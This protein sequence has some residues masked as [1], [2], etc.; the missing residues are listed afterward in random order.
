[1]N[2][3]K[4]EALLSEFLERLRSSSTGSAPTGLDPELAQTAQGLH[5]H[6]RLPEADSAAVARVKARALELT[7][8]NLYQA[9]NQR[10]N[11]DGDKILSFL[12]GANSN[13]VWGPRFSI[14]FTLVIAVPL[15]SFT[16]FGYYT[17]L[18]RVLSPTPRPVAQYTVVPDAVRW[19]NLG[20]HWWLGYAGELVSTAFGSFYTQHQDLMVPGRLLDVN[21]TRA[22]NS[23]DTRVGMFGLG[24]HDTYDMS[25]IDR[26]DGSVI[27]TFGDG[28]AGL[29]TPDGG[30]GYTAP[31]GFFAQLANNGSERV[32]TDTDQTAYTFSADGKLIRI[33]GPHG[34]QINLAH[35]ETGYT[36][37]DTVGREFRADFNSDG[38]IERITGPEGHNYTYEYSGNRLKAFHYPL[39]GVMRYTYNSDGL[40][41]SV[42]DANNHTFVTNEYDA[43][44][45]VVRQL[46]ASGNATTFTYSQSPFSTTIVDPENHTTVHEFDSQYR[47]VRETDALGHSIVYAYDIDNNRTYMK[48]RGDH[49]TFMQYDSRGNMTQR[50]DAAGG[51][52]TYQYDARN[53][54]TLERNAANEETAYTY[55]LRDNLTQV[56]DAENGVKL[57]TYTSFGQLQTLRDA[58]LHVTHFSYDGQGNLTEIRDALNNVTGYSYDGV[59]RRTSMTDANNHTT[60]FT[61]DANDRLTQINDPRGNSTLFTYD[62]VGNLLNMRDRRGYVTQYFYDEN[63]SLK[64]VLD[65][66]NSQTLYTY[67]RMY[68]RTSETNPRNFTTQYR[69]DA[70]YN[71]ER[72]IDAKNNVTRFEYDADR[73]MTRQIDALNGTTIFQYDALHRPIRVTD[74]LTGVTEYAYDAVGRRIQMRDARQ[75]ITRY[76]Y[77]HLGRLVE[78]T[79]ALN[80]HTLLGYD[81]VGN[82]TS[83]TNARRVTTTSRYDDANRLIE[84]SDPLGRLVAYSYDGVGNVRT[85]TDANGNVTQYEYDANE[86]LQ[87]AIDALNGVTQ[88]TYDEED[89]VL[90]ERDANNH[91]RTYGYDQ[92]GNVLTFTLPLG[93]QTLYAYD[94]NGNLESITNAKN[95]T[96][97]FGYDQLDLLR[98]QTTPLG[99]VTTNDYDPLRRLSRLTDAESHVTQYRYDAL[100]RL[101]IVI[102]ALNG[103]TQ[104][105]YDALGYMT[106]Y[107]D[108]NNH[109]TRFDVDLLGRTTRETDPLTHSWNYTYDGVGNT[110]TRL[111]ANLKLT[112]YA[113]DQRNRLA[114]TAYPSG[115]NVVYTY[116]PNG[117]L[118]ALADKSGSAQ[119]RYDPLDRLTESLRT[120]GILSGKKLTNRYDAVGNLLRVTYPDGNY[121]GYQYN[122]NDWQVSV[123]DPME[124]VTSYRHDDVGLTTR[125]TNPNGTWTDFRYDNDDRKTRVFNGK[126]EANSNLIS[127]FDYTLDRVGNRTRTIERMTRGQVI[128]WDK[129]YTYDPLYRLT[130]SVLTPGYNPAQS[131]TSEFTYDAV[132]NRR[133]MA[134]NIQDKPN[135]PPLR[136]PVTTQYTY[137]AANQMLTVGTTRFTYDA[138]GNRMAMSG[139]TRAIDYAYDFE[140]RLSSATTYDVLP[141]GSHK[142]DSTLDY[143]YDSLGR[144]IERGVI[145]NGVR[146]I[147]DFLYDGLGYD[148]LAQYVD[149]GEPRTTYY[150]RDLSQILSRHE[151]QGQGAGLQYFYHYDG[152]G[153]VSAWTNQSG[154]GVQEYT[155]SPYGRL[156]DN[157]GP[158]N[159]SNRTDP[160]NSVTWS[161]KMWD[162][163]TEL[164]HFGARDYDP[165]AGVWLTRDLY[166]GELG[167]PTSLHRYQYVLNNPTTLIDPHG[168]D[169]QSSGLNLNTMDW[170][171]MSLPKLDQSIMYGTNSYG[172]GTNGL[173]TTSADSL[174][175]PSTSK[176]WL[177]GTHHSPLTKSI[178]GGSYLG[179]IAIT[180]NFIPVSGSTAYEKRNLQTGKWMD[181]PLDFVFNSLNES[182]L[183]AE[184]PDT[185][186]KRLRADL[187]AGSSVAG[188]YLLVVGKATEIVAKNP[189]TGRI[190]YVGLGISAVYYGYGNLNAGRGLREIIMPTRISVVVPRV[191]ETIGRTAA[192][193]RAVRGDVGLWEHCGVSSYFWAGV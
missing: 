165:S 155:Y 157:T 167:E 126:P 100:G 193:N 97:R 45:R 170:R 13:R 186:T 11:L 156:I 7:R 55:D 151:I 168:F 21:F 174:S 37:T 89:N 54:L 40:L 140:N 60:L 115:T 61:Y 43:Q 133:A 91:T 47:L 58:N 17:F 86:N 106:S 20:P 180:G 102:D 158:D 169:S 109:R 192:V 114:S 72:V 22:Y 67:D 24:W 113:Y 104:Y 70:V 173:Y 90:T 31:D 175:Q 5:L 39:G 62:L 128:T 143:T 78:V 9:Q 2:S 120:A 183:V 187:R 110:L 44:G 145:D 152:S 15:L 162:K 188:G 96:T 166:R 147:A 185:L 1:M 118:T 46:D 85:R 14:L 159:A 12:R 131:L 125:M 64:R 172:A 134:T 124:G 74:A 117:N 107:I 19:A 103:Q 87:R 79:D 130:K 88:F 48:D 160:H 3:S 121:V 182:S 139:S 146:K 4:Q 137:D 108:A 49:E 164:Y 56:H 84:Q 95:N 191:G 138:N 178:S 135:T 148:M 112:R 77:D 99:N 181:D 57:M 69:Y 154:R 30:G 105:E 35:D 176:I 26:G 184:F 41:T 38:F 163:E 10:W 33:S 127:S 28:R 27:V 161:G 98:T 153:D 93:Q 80:G 190:P 122:A 68:N 50:T 51:V 16:V 132:G 23:L 18:Q 8:A 75:G 34:N 119:Y 92:V 94:P 177:A 52:W 36:L 83:V 63:D 111:D 76:F 150:Y 71:L 144:R 81:P 149:P 129:Q 59:S 42:T 6:L 73:N 53:N 142:F 101:T 65:A 32:L 29:Y 136:A 179:Y 82:R 189:L 171:N 123:M 116:D 141:N 25:A 66:R